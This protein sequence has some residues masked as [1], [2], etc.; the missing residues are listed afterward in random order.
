MN[1]VLFL[2]LFYIFLRWYSGRLISHCFFFS[3]CVLFMK[4][5]KKYALLKTNS[6]NDF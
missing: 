3:V 2:L 4:R 5:L 1:F 6:N